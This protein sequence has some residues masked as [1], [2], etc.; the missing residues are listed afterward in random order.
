MLVMAVLTEHR[1]APKGGADFLVGRCSGVIHAQRSRPCVLSV[2]ASLFNSLCARSRFAARQRRKQ[3]GSRA[4]CLLAL[5]WELRLERWRPSLLRTIAPCKGRGGCK[6][7]TSVRLLWQLKT[8]NHCC[9]G[10]GQM[11]RSDVHLYF[12]FL[13]AWSNF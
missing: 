4:G 10:H 1:D 13:P 8:T 2:G 12:L 6:S 3:S 11:Y 9:N 7:G 5:A